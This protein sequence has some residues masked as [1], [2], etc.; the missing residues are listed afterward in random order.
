MKLKYKINQF[1]F[2]QLLA[3]STLLLLAGF[4]NS[5]VAD[6]HRTDKSTLTVMTFNAE[7]MWDGVAPEEGN[8][9]IN[10]PWRG[11]QTLA[12]AHMQKIA[13]V[14]KAANPDIVN[15]VEVENLNALNTL[16]TKFLQGLG[17]QAYLVEGVDTFTGQ[18]VG[19]LT[20]ID[21][22]NNQIRYDN[23]KGNSANVSKS[24]SKDYVARI[25]FGNYKLAFIGLHLLAQPE[26][27][28][29]RLERQAQADAIKQIALDEKNAGYSLVILGD[30]NDF[31]VEDASLD[32]L[33]HKPIS[34]VLANIRLLDRNTELDD[35]VNVAK[36][37]EK[38][39]RYTAFW[40]QNNNNQV[41]APKEFSSIDHIL[42][43]P[44]LAGR[45]EKVDIPHNHNPL[46][47]S[48]HF[49]IVV[50]LRLFSESPADNST[51]GSQIVNPANPVTPSI[52]TPTPTPST[53]VSNPSNSSGRI[54]QKGPR[55]G[56]YYINDSGK[57]VYV[58]R[59]L[60][61]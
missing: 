7:F 61:N 46:E 6:D 23:R 43:S 51:G 32:H 25:K 30:F 54:Y 12:E 17:Y 55:G 31:D 28:D 38:S 8:S 21:P 60:C 14:I 57:K 48:D 1:Q 18:D 53:S 26:N 41:D 49:P 50:K 36:F 47:V 5:V 24:V 56:C 13:E 40:D 11:N 10:I 3:I 59:S 58:D 33:D 20:R 35:L 15:L 9:S 39:K 4:F 22:E 16:N 52:I 45:I 44:E 37:V 42:L 27:E 34:N 29:R 19:L 2:L